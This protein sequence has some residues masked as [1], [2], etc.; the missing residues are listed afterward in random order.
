[1][2]AIDGAQLTVLVGPLV[3]DADLVLLQPLHVGLAAQE[4][5]QF[6]NDTVEVDLL[7]GQQGKR[8]RQVIAKLGTEQGAGAGASAVAFGSAFFEDAAQEVLIGSLNHGR[9]DSALASVPCA[10]GLVPAVGLRV[11]G[12]VLQDLVCQL[13]AAD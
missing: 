3:P 10:R 5:Q 12:G 4:P 9:H 2:H 8:L 6:T 13:G 1:M 7:G 11:G